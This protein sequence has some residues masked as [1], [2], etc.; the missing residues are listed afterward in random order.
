MYEHHH[1]YHEIAPQPAELAQPVAVEAPAETAEVAGREADPYE[2]IDFLL[3]KVEE[4]ESR[5]A[6][7][8][9]RLKEH[10]GYMELQQQELEQ[11]KA[12]LDVARN[13]LEQQL[14]DY[15]VLMQNTLAVERE[16]ESYKQKSQ[17]RPKISLPFY[18][19]QKLAKLGY[20]SETV[21]MPA[22]I[23]ERQAV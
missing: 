8:D 5:L 20:G 3:K 18:T 15:E 21:E 11:L 10:E 14:G 7:K 12:Q 22:P 19:E 17:E 2:V 1:P 13:E 6:E 9:A 23:E 16:L 4:H